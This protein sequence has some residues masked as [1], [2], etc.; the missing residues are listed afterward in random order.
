MLLQI[1]VIIKIST[2]LVH[3]LNNCI[4]LNIPCSKQRRKIEMPIPTAKM[5]KIGATAANV[6]PGLFLFIL[7]MSL[8]Q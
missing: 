8:L 2:I 3:S 5:V 7:G 4:T 1:I 6:T